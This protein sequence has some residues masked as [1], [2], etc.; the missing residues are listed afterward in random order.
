[1]WVTHDIA[2]TE[3]FGR[4]LV[5]DAGRIVEDGDPAELG[6][7]PGS[8]YAALVRADRDLRATEWSGAR[9]RHVW[10]AQGKVRK[11]GGDA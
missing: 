1:L 4:V 6:S 7:R 10:L 2:E 11:D 9:W 8:R 3:S 5:I